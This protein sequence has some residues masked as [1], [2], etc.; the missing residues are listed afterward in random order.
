MG[1]KLHQC[2]KN[3]SKNTCKDKNEDKDKIKIQIRIEMEMA[4]RIEKMIRMGVG[5]EKNDKNMSRN[6]TKMIRKMVK[7]IRRMVR[8]IKMIRIW[9]RTGRLQNRWEKKEGGRRGRAGLST[10]RRKNALRVARS[11][12][13]RQRA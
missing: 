5:M 6:E 13:Q 4:V 2:S 7:I 10:Q 12:S 11:L 8:M 3:G 9:V 1:E